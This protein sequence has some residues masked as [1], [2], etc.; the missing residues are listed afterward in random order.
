MKLKDLFSVVTGNELIGLSIEGERR[1]RFD[2]LY[3]C[4]ERVLNPELLDYEVAEIHTSL[5][6]V[7]PM[8]LVRIK[9]QNSDI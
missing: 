7:S 6:N 8:L 1:Y 2:F 4:W 5:R 3:P 9:A